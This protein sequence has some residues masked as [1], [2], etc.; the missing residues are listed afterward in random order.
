MLHA[1]RGRE[2]VFPG[3]GQIRLPDWTGRGSL[4]A[5]APKDINNLMLLTLFS[6][7]VMA[8]GSRTRIYIR[9]AEPDVRFKHADAALI[10]FSEARGLKKIINF[11]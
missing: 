8:P 4:R 3:G 1:K 7:C 11:Y 6:R 5:P 9:I 2:S 10:L